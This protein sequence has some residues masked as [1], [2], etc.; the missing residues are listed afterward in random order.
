MTTAELLELIEGLRAGHGIPQHVELKR[1]DGERPRRLWTTLSACANTPGGG[2]IILGLDPASSTSVAGVRRPKRVLQELEELCWAME[3]PLRPVVGLHEVEGKT[4]LVAEVAEVDPGQKPCYYRGAGLASGAFIRTATGDRQLT[5]YEVELMQ[6]ARGQPREDEAAV[7]EAGLADLDRELVRGLLERRRQPEGSV[8]RRLSDEAALQTLKVL[9]PYQ[10]RLVPSLAG[11][12]ALGTYPQQFFPMQGL[13]LVVYPTPR[14]GE[15]GPNG[16]RFLA[17]RRFDG[18]LPRL[19]P[20]AVAGVGQVLQPGPLPQSSEPG[21]EARNPGVQQRSER[22]GMGCAS[23]PELLEAV[24]E[25]VV[26]ALVHRDMSVLARSMPVQ[27]QVFPDRWTIV[28]PGGLFGPV[29]LDRLGEAGTSAARNQ[30]LMKLMED[31]S[32]AGERRP[33]CENR[34]SGLSALLAASRQAGMPPPRFVD[35]RATFEVTFSRQPLLDTSML[36]WLAALQRRSGA[37]LTL[38]QRLVLATMRREALAEGDQESEPMTSVRYRQIT[39]VGGRAAT[40]EL[41]EL[42]VRGL[43]EQI[44]TQRWATYRLLAAAQ[45]PPAIAPG[46]APPAAPSLD[47]PGRPGRPDLP[48]TPDLP[49][50][51]G[52]EAVPAGPAGQAPGPTPGARRDVRQEILAALQEGEAHSR[53]E[54][55][56]RLGLADAVVRKWLASLRREGRVIL[57]TTSARSQHTRYRLAR[58]A[59]DGL[60][61]GVPRGEH[62]T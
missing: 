28:N 55:A 35:H 13:T 23:G 7:P 6:A 36:Q 9:V 16:E 56:R 37:T 39:G 52:H 8:F 51:T 47:R 41:G 12:L 44:G 4:V 46:D 45:P 34:A 5:P 24:R 53:A 11:L 3:P 59:E 22:L 15:A 57:T 18:P 50:L 21:A 31:V 62:A 33:I 29:T 49:G 58:V 2:V 48:D 27:V 14:A 20:A 54:L 42:V 61:G 40:R 38:A 19:V 10:D 26:N 32:A 1:A 60:A 17:S 30:V 43:V 25:A